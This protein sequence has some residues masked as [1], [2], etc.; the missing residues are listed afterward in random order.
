MTDPTEPVIVRSA[1][2]E[3]PP[4]DSAEGSRRRVRRYLVPGLTVVAVGLLAV[5][6]PALAQQT[7]RGT[8]KA[9]S[10]SGFPSGPPSTI[11]PSLKVVIV[12]TGQSTAP[13]PRP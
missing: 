5:A 13:P 2:P 8:P 7:G 1:R 10:S 11:D 9:A 4:S 6:V 12:D 3:D